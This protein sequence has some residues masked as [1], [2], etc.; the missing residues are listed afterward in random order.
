[1]NVITTPAGHTGREPCLLAATC[2]A[3]PPLAVARLPHCARR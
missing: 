2:A 1:M 3:S